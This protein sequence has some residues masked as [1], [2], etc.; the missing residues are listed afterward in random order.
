MNG[1]KKLYLY[2]SLAILGA[3]VAYVIITKKKTMDSSGEG[4]GIPD[5]EETTVVTTTTGDVIDQTQVVIP[6]SLSE[7]LKKTS[8]QATSALINKP[9]YTKLDGVKVRSEN[10]VNNGFINN[11][12]STITDRKTLL[13]NVIQVVDDK[14]KLKNLD[15]RVYKW[16]KIKPD[17]STLDEMN[18]NK[19]FLQSTFLPSWCKAIYV[20]EDAVQ[21]E[22]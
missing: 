22:K 20:R 21:L 9:I 15:G 8:A 6:Q 7:I 3:I 16:F 12:W 4:S 1:D 13:G 18:K 17:Q 19:D 10:Y 14:G 11:I 5:A 2:S